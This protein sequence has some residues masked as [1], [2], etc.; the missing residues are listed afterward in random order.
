ML[1]S[2]LVATQVEAGSASCIVVVYPKPGQVLTAA[3]SSFIFGHVPLPADGRCYD[4]HINGYPVE[5]HPEGGFLAF[6]PIH[7]GRFTFRLSAALSATN[8]E[9]YQ[10]RI[11]R[12][13]PGAGEPYPDSIVDSLVVQVPQPLVALSPDSLA[14]AGEYQPPAGDVFLKSG[15]ILHVSFRGTPGCRAW[16]SLPGVS[17]SVAMSETAASAQPFWGETVFGAGKIP[18][19][20]LIHGVYQGCVVLTDMVHVEQ[21]RVVFHLVPPTLAQV[22]ANLFGTERAAPSYDIVSY[23]KLARFDTTAQSESSYRVSVNSA[24]FPQAVRFADSVQIVRHGPR[25]GYL[26]IFQPEGIEALAVGAEGDWLKLQLSATQIGWVQARSVERLG[27]GIT[28]P[29]SLLRSI[30]TLRC[31]HGVQI[32]CPLLGKHPF[33][34]VE[35]DRRTVRL[36]LFGVTADTDWI[37]YDHSDSLID[38]A[39]WEQVEPGLFQLKLALTRDIWGYDAFYEGAT[40]CLKIQSAPANSRTLRGLRIAVDPGHSADPGAIGPT[41]YTEAEA[42]LALALELRDQLE[43]RGAQVIMTR[44]DS[45]DV[46]LYARPA[47][48]KAAGADL[49]ISVHNNALPDGINPF[50]NNGSSTYY[51]QLHSLD[52]AKAVH[53]RLV[54]ATGL[55]DLGLFYG[56]LAV[57]RPTQYPAVLVECAFMMIPEQETLLKTDSFR[58]QVAEGIVNGLEDFLKEHGRD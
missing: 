17:D 2:M 5:V 32:S 44:Q 50:Q 20:L 55:A 18:D 28:P 42:N 4:L 12:G 43:E 15:D 13:L 11:K 51:Y 47:I 9:P 3:D 19:S 52:L 25:Q 6:V 22:A 27:P 16:F 37:R 56:N 45:S 58:R 26:S 33:R 53:R 54:P 41:G 36:Q 49:F 24:L 8:C 29:A 48:A 31:D 39:S 1:W 21:A 23:F 35:D 7:P 46:S 10:S 38:F 30:R 14:I 34:V 57:A 40:F